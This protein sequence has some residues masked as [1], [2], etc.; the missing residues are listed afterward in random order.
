MNAYFF[1]IS[2][3][4]WKKFLVSHKKNVILSHVTFS[5]LIHC[6]NQ[7]NVFASCQKSFM[8]RF[9]FIREKLLC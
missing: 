4:A 9:L 1:Q 5:E 8:L 2:S 6:K 7:Q 3:S